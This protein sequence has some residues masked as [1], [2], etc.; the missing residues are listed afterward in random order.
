MTPAA[1]IIA[2][3]AGIACMILAGVELVRQASLA[4]DAGVRWPASRWWAGL[5]GDPSWATTGV[6]AGVMIA[7][8]IVLVILA[9]RQLGDRRRGPD[10]VEFAAD[11]ARARL[12]VPGLEQALARRFEA[13]VPGSRVASVRLTKIAAGWCARVEASLPPRDVGAARRRALEALRGD[14]QRIG[15]LDLVRLDVVVTALRTAGGKSA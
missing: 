11:D 8:T 14:L 2:V 1:R 13:V 5:T 9:V 6:A 12:S 3:V 10:L 7:V 4:A 15:G